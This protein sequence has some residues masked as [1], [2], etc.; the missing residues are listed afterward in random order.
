MQTPGML[1]M[2]NMAPGSIE[3]MTSYA[4]TA[5]ARGLRNFLVT[6]SLTDSLALAASASKLRV[7]SGTGII[8]CNASSAAGCATCADDRST[9]SGR[10]LLGPTSHV[11][12]NKAYGI[13]RINR[14]RLREY[15]STVKSVFRGEYEGSGK[16]LPGL[17]PFAPT[18]TS[19]YVADFQR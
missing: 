17:R 12:T 7:F 15:V 3:R 5:E 14:Y 19:R 2:S 8:N 10:V 18:R 9:H 13:G 1:I 4:Q 16:R 11:P 6:E